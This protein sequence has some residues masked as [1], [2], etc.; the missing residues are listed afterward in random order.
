MGTI[1][2]NVLLGKGLQN[3]KEYSFFVCYLF[4]EL[5]YSLKV[6]FVFIVNGKV[7]AGYNNMETCT[8]QVQSLKRKIG[9]V[10][11]WCLCATIFIRY[12]I[13]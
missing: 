3:K 10:S 11:V 13:I 1:K 7:V 12:E 8:A 4:V 5:Q 9:K 2:I 6:L